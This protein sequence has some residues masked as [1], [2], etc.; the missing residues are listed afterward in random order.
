M[1]GIHHGD[2]PPHHN[3]GPLMPPP[4]MGG[5]LFMSPPPPLMGQVRSLVGVS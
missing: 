2:M 1:Q 3:M 4:H 5:P